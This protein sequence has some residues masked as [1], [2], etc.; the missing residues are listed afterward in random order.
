MSGR[1]SLA[2]V[3]STSNQPDHLARVLD[4]VSRLAVLPGEFVLADDGSG[5]DTK[6][7]FDRWSEGRPFPCFHV[8][9][10]KAGFRKS[11][12]LNLAIARAPADYLVFLDGDT[13]PHPRFLADHHEAARPGFFVQGHRALIDRQAADWFGRGSF[14]ADRRRALFSG[15][16][17]GWK[18]AFRW[19]VPL[20]RKRT[21]LRGIRGCNLGIRLI[22]S[23]VRRLDLRGRALCYHLWHPP[24]SRNGL[25]Q[26]DRLLEEAIAKKTVRC[27][28]G[29]D[30]HP[31][32]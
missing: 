8:W 4:A 31:S 19:P 6:S 14:G 9:Q 20:A 27:E 18:N 13:V 24:A 7:L 23:G 15:Q 12:I 3:M 5:R 16:I 11:R 22:N 17:K 25:V 26:N 28:R 21:D 2:L 30:Q 29:L 32:A 1:P 10:E